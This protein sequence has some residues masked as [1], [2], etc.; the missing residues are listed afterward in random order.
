MVLYWGRVV[1]G[2][3]TRTKS[4]ISI[5]S[6]DLIEL[7]SPFNPKIK[8]TKP[9]QNM[10]FFRL[11]QS[12]FTKTAVFATSTAAALHIFS[13]SSSTTVPTSSFFASSSSSSLSLPILN[14]N[15]NTRKPRNGNGG[16]R[17]VSNY[18]RKQKALSQ[19]KPRYTAP[20]FK[21]LVSKP[22]VE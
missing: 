22:V 3:H 12:T 17:A 8:T 11:S 5:M 9:I 16:K 20:T 15:R 19:R 1:R 14:M 7:H 13:L 18:G 10:A 4:I 6:L 21:P 2:S